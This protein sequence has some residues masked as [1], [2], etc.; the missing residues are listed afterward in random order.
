M[1]RGFFCCFKHPWPYYFTFNHCLFRQMI[2]TCI[3]LHFIYIYILGSFPL[4]FAMHIIL[5]CTS[6][7]SCWQMRLSVSNCEEQHSTTLWPTKQNAVF[8]AECGAEVLDGQFPCC[9]CVSALVP[10][11]CAS[12]MGRIHG[13]Q[14]VTSTSSSSKEC[15]W[16]RGFISIMS[17]NSRASPCFLTFQN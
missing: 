14:E 17:T 5:I 15:T 10:F 7:A 1:Q 11:Q 6:P 3:Y 9:A 8:T 16:K 13:M 12:Q 2:S 4:V